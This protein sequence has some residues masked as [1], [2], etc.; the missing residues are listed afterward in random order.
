MN[1]RSANHPP[2]LGE[3]NLAKE[4]YQKP[5]KLLQ[6]PDVIVIGSGI[7]GLGVASIF[8]QRK[9]WKVLVLEANSVPG[10]CLHNHELGGFE[11]NSGIDSI[12]DMD[13][14]KGRGLYRPTIDYLTKGMLEWAKMPDVHEVCFFG[15]DEYKWY[16]SPRKNMAWIKERFGINA[17]AYYDLE[18]RIEDF[19]TVWGVTKVIP[20]WVPLPLHKGFYKAFGGAWRKYMFRAT[21]D[22]FLKELKFP[23]KL[24]SAFCYMYGNH[25]RTPD[26]APFA[27]HAVNLIHYRYGAYYPV[28]GSG[29]IVECMVPIIEDPGGQVAVSSAVKRIIVEANTAVGVEL[30]S[31]EIIRSKLVISDAGAYNTFME[32]LPRD[33]AE[34]HGYPTLF[35]DIGPSPAHC[36]LFL[37]YDEE[38]E[39]PKQIYWEMPG[40]DISEADR[41]YKEEGDIENSM[42]AYILCPSARDPVYSERY[43]GKSTVICLAEAPYSWIEKCREN[44]DF[45]KKFEADITAK[46]VSIVHKRIPQ[47]RDKT[48]SFQ[49]AGVPIGC[50]PRAWEACSLGLEPSGDRFVKH[51]H[52][53][54]P[55]TKVKN[56]YLTGQ[57]AF[58]MGF[59]GSM[60]ASRLCYSAITGNWLFSL[61]KKPRR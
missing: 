24:A 22:V 47:L 30:E 6:N 14:S 60:M 2:Y 50:N 38:I 49:L 7:G 4:K 61:V 41:R 32:M 11:W 40:Y 58:S 37:G 57:D 45:K 52:W 9:R 18:E 53:T 44:P 1:T 29:Q 8:A 33:V 20:D 42:G 3:N 17:K 19:A 46:L 12:G 35:D 10:G 15:D 39:L 34:R 23:E 16:S 43:P 5:E 48:P 56:L 36:S 28:G 31:G 21:M 13:A 51:T 55:K 25:G 54:K 59:C 27:F 26:V